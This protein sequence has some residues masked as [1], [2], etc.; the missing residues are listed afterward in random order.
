MK[1]VIFLVVLSFY[2]F[3]FQSPIYAAE[4]AKGQTVADT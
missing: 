4:S 2:L 1:R 3:S